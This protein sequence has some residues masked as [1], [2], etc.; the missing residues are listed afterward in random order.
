MRQY[1]PDQRQ[2]R[3]IGRLEQQESGGKLGDIRGCSGH[4]TSFTRRNTRDRWTADAPW[5][6]SLGLAPTVSVLARRS[7]PDQ[8]IVGSPWA[9]RS[10][11]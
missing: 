5:V 4:G 8:K 3:R 9:G 2:Y 11:G 10:T 7:R 1:F 6:R